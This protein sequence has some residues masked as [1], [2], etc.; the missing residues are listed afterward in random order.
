MIALEMMVHVISRVGRVHS[1]DGTSELAVLAS[2][3]QEEPNIR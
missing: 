1:R 3:E 2:G